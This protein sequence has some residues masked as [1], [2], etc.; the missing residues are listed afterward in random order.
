LSLDGTEYVQHLTAKYGYSAELA[1]MLAYM[2]AAVKK[3][4]EERLSDTVQ[5]VTGA[6]PEGFYDFAMRQ[7]QCWL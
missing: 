6:Y 2:D 1:A 3:G 5:K 7:R 4:S